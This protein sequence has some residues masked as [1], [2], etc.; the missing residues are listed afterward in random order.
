MSGGD[1]ELVAGT[2]VDQQRCAIGFVHIAIAAGKWWTIG[3]PGDLAIV[4]VECGNKLLVHSVADDDK[5][6]V[7][8][9][10]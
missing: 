4:F 3:L 6:I 10:R 9:E 5:E 8:E 1:D 7:V 2:V